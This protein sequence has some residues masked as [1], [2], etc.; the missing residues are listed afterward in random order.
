MIVYFKT[1]NVDMSII[2]LTNI[3]INK[4]TNIV[5]IFNSND[6]KI[7]QNNIVENKLK[8]MYHRFFYNFCNNFYNLLSPCKYL[9]ALVKYNVQYITLRKVIL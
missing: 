6:S 8:H 3:L 4:Y 2:L 5:T 7:Q 9:H 1:I